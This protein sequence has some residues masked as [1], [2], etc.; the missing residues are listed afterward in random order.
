MKKIYDSANN[1][2][3]NRGNCEA[4]DLLEMIKNM[5]DSCSERVFCE[6]AYSL[7]S[8]YGGVQSEK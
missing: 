3:V 2:E 7:K 6:M 1:R 5:C 8:C 4:L